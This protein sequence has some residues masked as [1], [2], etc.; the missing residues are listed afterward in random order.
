MLTFTDGAP[1][2]YAGRT[3]TIE[4]WAPTASAPVIG[5]VLALHGGRMTG[6][7]PVGRLDLPMLRMFAI[8]RA[9]HDRLASEG[10][11][12][13]TLRYAVQGWNGT[14]ASPVADAR[15]AL[16]RIAAT[17]GV[18]V[19]L[20][21]HSMGARTALRIAGEPA[22][23]GV[24]ALAPWLPPGEPMGDLAGRRLI[25]AHGAADRTTDPRSSR[26]Y[27]TAARRRATEVSYVEVPGEGHALLRKPGWWNRFAATSVLDLL[28]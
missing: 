6:R 15:W 24:V 8:A 28:T 5:A 14:D 19:A 22:V 25:V 4:R 10:I 26:E 17:D 2:Q 23:T 20:L 27:A 9:V 12:V 1:E 16:D 18:P 13:W 11:A 3:A 7:R 21:G